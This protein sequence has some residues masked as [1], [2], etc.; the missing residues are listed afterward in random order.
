MTLI[1]KPTY[2]V[3]D[4]SNLRTIV[5]YNKLNFKYYLIPAYH[6]LPWMGPACV[7]TEVWPMDILKHTWTKWIF[8][9][10]SLYITKSTLSKY[11]Y[12]G[13]PL[14]QMIM[15]ES[16]KKWMER[17]SS[18]IRQASLKKIITLIKTQNPFNRNNWKATMW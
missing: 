17:Q 12:I 2:G 18:K 10:F 1:N 7:Q 6:L 16:P 14:S 9:F 3:A 13:W 8:I 11:T 4:R 5:T 15:N